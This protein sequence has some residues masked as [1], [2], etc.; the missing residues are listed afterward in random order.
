MLLDADSTGMETN[1]RVSFASQ[2]SLFH[3]VHP[4]THRSMTDNDH[5]FRDE[6][7]TIGAGIFPVSTQH[8]MVLGVTP[9]FFASCFWQ[10]TSEMAKNLEKTSKNKQKHDRNYS[11]LSMPVKDTLFVTTDI[12][13]VYWS[14][15]CLMQ[16]CRKCVIASLA[17]SSV[18]KL[19]SKQWT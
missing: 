11:S 9:S 19:V 8:R 14:A 3:E 10:I 1:I 2:F 17:R 4:L 12:F 6:L 7:A 5:S 13:R 18:Q 15:P 16:V